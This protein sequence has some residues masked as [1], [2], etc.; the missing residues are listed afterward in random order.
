[1]D[2]KDIRVWLNPA[3][4]YKMLLWLVVAMELLATME[5]PQR[6]DSLIKSNWYRTTQMEEKPCKV[7]V[8]KTIV[9]IL[10]VVV[11]NNVARLFFNSK[12]TLTDNQTSSLRIVK[13]LMMTFKKL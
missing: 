10:V 12:I 9:E 7:L 3:S 11:F 2:I 8:N 13:V 1:M 6:Q 5:V 4:S